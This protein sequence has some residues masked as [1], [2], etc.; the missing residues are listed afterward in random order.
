MYTNSDGE[1]ITI[2]GEF[3]NTKGGGSVDGVY[4]PESFSSDE[5]AGKT[6]RVK[7]RVVTVESG[8]TVNEAGE[9]STGWESSRRVMESVES[10]EVIE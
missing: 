6:V 5:Y 10:I 7:G 9:Y 8:S 4:L 2:E 3:M 1:I